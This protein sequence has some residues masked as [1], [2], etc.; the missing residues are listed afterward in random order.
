MR[1]RA[2]LSEND[3]GSNCRPFDAHRSVALGSFSVWLR[4]F[5]PVVFSTSR[6]WRIT[7]SERVEGFVL[8]NMEHL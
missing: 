1:G 2:T 6:Q 3:S 8:S 7:V 5:P 4:I